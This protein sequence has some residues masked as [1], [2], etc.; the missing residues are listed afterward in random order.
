VRKATLQF[1]HD[2]RDE[3]RVDIGFLEAGRREIMEIAAGARKNVTP[4]VLSRLL[5]RLGR[6]EELIA[7]YEARLG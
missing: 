6:F 3:L 5:E 4:A 1:L 2:E 7:A